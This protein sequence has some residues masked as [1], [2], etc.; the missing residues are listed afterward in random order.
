[1]PLTPPAPV[2][3]RPLFRPVSAALVELL[4]GLGPDDWHRLTIAGTWTVRDVVAHLVDLSFR[5]LSFHRDRMVPPPPP[6]PITSEREFVDFING[7]NAEWI[8]AMRRLSP[9]VLTDLFEKASADLADWFEA[10]PLDA[11]ALFG[12][13]WAGEQTSEGWFDVGREFTEL[14]HH[15]EQIR[16]AVGAPPLEDPRHLSAVLGVAVRV[17][18]HAF[19]DLQAGEGTTVTLEITGPS[20]GTWSIARAAGRWQ[21]HAGEPASPDARVRIADADAWK[22]FFNALRGQ[23]ATRAV[24]IEGRRDLASPLLAA[25]SIV[26]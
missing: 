26:V 4:R 11:P 16:L 8:G 5:R 15:Q 12:V 22:L 6:R 10:L 23:D 14:W 7:L 20:G 3:T 21:L 2:D 18:P 9:R 17:L 25:R 19:R 24:Q 13:S 1:M